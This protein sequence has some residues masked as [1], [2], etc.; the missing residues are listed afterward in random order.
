MLK[1]N[2]LITIVH[3]MAAITRREREILGERERGGD[4]DDGAGGGGGGG[5]FIEGGIASDVC[6]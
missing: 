5:D 2:K 6:N 4:G 3:N 1:T